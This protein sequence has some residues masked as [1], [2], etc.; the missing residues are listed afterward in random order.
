MVEQHITVSHTYKNLFFLPIHGGRTLVSWRKVLLYLGLFILAILGHGSER[1][2]TVVV[3][4]EDEQRGVYIT[5][6]GPM[7]VVSRRLVNGYMV[8]DE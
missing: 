8:Y 4:L 5:P 6:Y 3:P 7:I 1:R 2:H